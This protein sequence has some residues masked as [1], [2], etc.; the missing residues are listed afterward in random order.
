MDA[1]VETAEVV[2]DVAAG[3]VIGV[4]VQGAPVLTPE[5]ERQATDD[6]GGNAARLAVN[7]RAVGE[8]RLDT[9]DG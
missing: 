5:M 1:A 4:A 6:I 2:A 9:G 7:S 3:V 8:S